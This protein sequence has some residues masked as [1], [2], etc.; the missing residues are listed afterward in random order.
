MTRSCSTGGLALM[1]GVGLAALSAGCASPPPD[2]VDDVLNRA[3]RAEQTSRYRIAVAPLEVE[4][5]A[6]VR[7]ASEETSSPVPIDRSGFEGEVVR[8]VEGSERFADTTFLRALARRKSATGPPAVEGPVSEAAGENDAAPANESNAGSDTGVIYETPAPVNEEAL[9]DLAFDEGADLILR[10]R[11]KRHHTD[12]VDHNGWF[13][14]N[15]INFAFAIW[16]A[17]F[18]A[19]EQYE[20]QITVEAEL[21]SVLNRRPVSTRVFDIKSG[22]KDLDHF[23]RGWLALGSL[24]TPEWLTPENYAQAGEVVL[25]H[26]QNQLDKELSSYLATVPLPTTLM[27]GKLAVC[28]GVGDYESR[29]QRAAVFSD[30]A[31]TFASLLSDAASVPEKNI[32]LLTE[33]QPTAENVVKELAEWAQRCG[34]NDTIFFYFA[35]FGFQAGDELFLVPSDVEPTNPIATAIPLSRIDAALRGAKGRQVLILDTSF[36]PNDLLAKGVPAV[37]VRTFTESAGRARELAAP[38]KSAKELLGHF[39]KAKGRTVILGTSAGEAA[40]LVNAELAEQRGFFTARLVK[41]LANPTSD[42]SGD[43]SLDLQEMFDFANYQTLRRTQATEIV[44]EPEVLGVSP[45]DIRIAP[46]IRIKED[47]K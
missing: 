24:V 35:G 7:L 8:V 36:G 17:Y 15:Q 3:T 1:L 4:P 45:K 31:R 33:A 27:K 5:A 28:V 2:S 6:A 11:A 12:F 21:L 44:Q 23:D 14:L 10:L 30:D 34:P 19:D 37:P 16:P 39:A 40:H 9:Y 42:K 32:R 41:S 26:A 20:G 22:P 25:R 43:K 13:W 29:V 46:A 47:K 38:G 18:V